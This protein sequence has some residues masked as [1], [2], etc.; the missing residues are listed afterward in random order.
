MVYRVRGIPNLRD[1]A[2]GIQ[3]QRV[4]VIQSQKDTELERYRVREIRS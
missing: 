4:R 3:S 1:A 2:R